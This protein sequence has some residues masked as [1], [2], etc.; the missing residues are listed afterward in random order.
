MFFLFIISID[1]WSGRL[2]ALLAKQR[3]INPN[4]PLNQR[5]E[6]AQVIDRT[7]FSFLF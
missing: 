6:V 1:D 4:T 3:M 2:Q 7:Y 5:V